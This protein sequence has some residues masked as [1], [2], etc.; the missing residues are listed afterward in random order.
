MFASMTG[1][2]TFAVKNV[3]KQLC[4]KDSKRLTE[5]INSTPCVNKA[6]AEFTKCYTQ[7]IDSLQGA[8]Y[9]NESKRIPHLCC[10]YYKMYP[11]FYERTKRFPICSTK[12]V[13][14]VS[15][16]VRNIF[17]NMVG[18]IC[19]DYTENSD[20]CDHLE[21]PPKKPKND[22]R[23]KSFAIPLIEILSSFPEI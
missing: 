22:K 15:D 11:C 19:G 7:V 17:D 4:K 21:L 14:T 10:E 12:K 20:K 3:V 2:L 16:F 8:K 5:I 23:T 18:L 13:D 9:A 1:V 6:N